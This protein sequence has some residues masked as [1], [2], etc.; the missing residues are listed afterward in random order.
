[1][2]EKQEQTDVMRMLDLMPKMSSIAMIMPHMQATLAKAMLRQ[3]KEILTFLNQRCDADIKL[4][5]ELSKS[6]DI[7]SL[8]EAY[9]GFFRDAAKAYV[10][11]A[12]KEADVG[13]ATLVEITK[14][15]RAVAN[16]ANGKK[17]ESKAA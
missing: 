4:F 14:E 6:E 9:S 17:P 1:M 10:E 13:S 2:A 5:E 3:Q 11:E 15:M 7:K 16:N 8:S 12:K